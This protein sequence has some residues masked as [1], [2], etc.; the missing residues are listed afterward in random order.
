MRKQ[1]LV[2]LATAICAETAFAVASIDLLEILE[3]PN[4]DACSSYLPGRL[5]EEENKKYPGIR[6]VSLGP[7]DSL[8]DCSKLAAAWK[9]PNDKKQLHCQTACWFR[10]N[11]DS[12][13]NNIDQCVCLTDPLW[14]PK[15][16]H[17]RTTKEPQ[18]DTARLVW[19]CRDDSDCSFNGKCSHVDGRCQCFPAWKGAVCGE[20]DVRP[21]DRKRL[22]FR[23]VDE[24]GQN[25]S[26]SWG[27]PILWDEVSKKWHGFASE[28]QDGCGINAWETN[29][30]I[31]H[32]E[33]NSPY[34]PFLKTHVLFSAFAHEPSVVRGPN[35]EWVMLFSSYHYNASA[36]ADVVCGNCKGGVTPEI[37][38][39][40][41]YQLGTP[42][43]L[44]HRFR[45]MQSVAPSPNGPWS[46]PVEIPQLSAGW[47]WNT[48]LTIHEDGSAV[49][50]IRGGSTWHAKDYTNPE[51]WKPVGARA[52]GSF[53]GPGW[54]GVSVEDPFIW[55]QDGVYHGLAHAFLP[56]YG[57]HAF[58]PIPPPDF[59]WTFPLNWT[60]TGVAYDNIVHFVDGT[61][62]AYARR[63]RPHLTFSAPPKSSRKRA[64][65]L[66]LS[67]GVQYAGKLRQ[68]F[69]DGAFTLVQPLGP[70]D[71]NPVQELNQQ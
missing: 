50:L 62:H 64:I 4:I 16:H 54:A 56:F 7:S 14:M 12:L 25:T 68:S 67:N 6:V 35:G 43:S 47:D 26:S 48:A 10:H 71:T 17:T 66:S 15:Q 33:G 52:T 59:D 31:V 57:V 32:I 11:D 9:D 70:E 49:A 21:V 23:Q 1:R 61:T 5:T 29:S 34:G 45:Q 18:I 40:C 30:R 42:A 3:Y 53:Q 51:T 41:P 27:A 65:P 69:R 55:Q 22:G 37:S 46:T 63:E 28:I 19:S 39:Q 38:S 8:T 36:L 24:H 58:V 20:L 44:H 2:I 60:V 13:V